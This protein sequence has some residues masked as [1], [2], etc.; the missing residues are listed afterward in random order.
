MRI[1]AA[2][3]TVHPQ[4]RG[5]ECIGDKEAVA[6]QIKS[7]E[8][9]GQSTVSLAIPATAMFHA[10][11]RVEEMALRSRFEDALEKS[12]LRMFRVQA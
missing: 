3:I 1:C 6:H 7:G 5:L 11:R 9:E 4:Q 12:S 10:V 8:L 2:P